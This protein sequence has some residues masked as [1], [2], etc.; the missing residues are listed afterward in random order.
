MYEHGYTD[1]LSRMHS[2][3]S[4]KSAAAHVA[5]RGPET[6]RSGSTASRAVTVVRAWGGGVGGD[7]MGTTGGEQRTRTDNQSRIL[8]KLRQ[9]VPPPPC[10]PLHPSLLTHSL[11]PHVAERGRRPSAGCGHM[12]RASVFLPCPHI[13]RN[14][15]W[16]WGRVLKY[17]NYIQKST[18]NSEAVGARM[19]SHYSVL[20]HCS[21]T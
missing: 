19:K 3:N 2:A 5:N 6:D 11:Q 13:F 1:S 8:W 15:G 9:Q 14:C 21:G 20:F 7:A 12:Q 18:R 10:T 4:W 16:W 17:H